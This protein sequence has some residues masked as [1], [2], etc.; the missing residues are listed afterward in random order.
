MAEAAIID[1]VNYR[2]LR[3]AMRYHRL[4]P[5]VDPAAGLPDAVVEGVEDV[6]ERYN[7]C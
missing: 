1:I 3:A 4:Q 2:I 6:Q 5:S 7:W